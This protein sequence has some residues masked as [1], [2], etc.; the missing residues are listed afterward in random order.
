M[1]HSILPI[2]GGV[3]QPPSTALTRS[4]LHSHTLSSGAAQAVGRATNGAFDLRRGSDR[5]PQSFRIDLVRSVL[6]RGVGASRLMEMKAPLA[7]F[8]G[9]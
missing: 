8:S 6:E 1:Q 2:L 3:K 9:K 7:L 5:Q 4:R